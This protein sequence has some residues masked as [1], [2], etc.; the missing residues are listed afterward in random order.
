MKNNLRIDLQIDLDGKKLALQQ[1]VLEVHLQDI[2]PTDGPIDMYSAPDMMQRQERRR[3]LVDALS[4]N[5]AH[6]ITESLFKVGGR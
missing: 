4:G 1:V 6:A 5:L 2:L 3:R